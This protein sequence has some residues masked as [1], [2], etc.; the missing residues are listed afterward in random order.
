MLISS[1]ESAV[2]FII[3]QTCANKYITINEMIVYVLYKQD[4][5]YSVCLKTCDDRMDGTHALKSHPD[6]AAGDWCVIGNH[7][8][9]LNA[10][11]FEK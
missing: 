11:S 7:S 9:T 2:K 1:S 6:I 3:K 5:V 8:L 4:E 10:Q